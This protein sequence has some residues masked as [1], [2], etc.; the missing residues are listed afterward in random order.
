MYQLVFASTATR[1]LEGSE[2]TS[3]LQVFRA[4]HEELGVTGILLYKEGSFL[5]ILEGDKETVVSLYEVLETADYHKGLTKL[6]ELHVPEREFSDWSM[7]WHQP[8]QDPQEMPDGYTGFM[9]EGRID[10]RETS[11]ALQ[12][13]RN[14]RDLTD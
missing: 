3:L 9:D 13:L 5:H 11:Q 6:M 2:L 7:S 1:L 10:L 4:R 12:V 8:V 14:F